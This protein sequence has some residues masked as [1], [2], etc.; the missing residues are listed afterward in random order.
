MPCA[1]V[2]GW[3]RLSQVEDRLVLRDERG[4]TRDSLAWSAAFWGSWPA[5]RSRERRSRTE[6]TTMASNW[7]ASPDAL[8][9]T[10]GWAFGA[11]PGWA[12]PGTATFAVS[13]PER[14]FC[15]GDAKVQPVLPIRLTAP[16][17]WKMTVSVF[18][19]DRRQ[20]RHLLQGNAPASGLL[21][22]D[23][24][25]DAG[26]SCRM[27][28]YLVLVEATTDEGRMQLRRE[29]AVLGRRL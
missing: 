10:P 3:M 22:W 6:A 21:E 20:V 27:G 11:A 1:D 8:G 28:T 4:A 23:G 13:I 9:A 26:R 12:E 29:W 18:D 16:P 25:D 14:L 15:P 24:R 7:I 17:S 5:G 2:P 19:L